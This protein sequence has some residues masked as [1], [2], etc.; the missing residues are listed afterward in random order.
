VSE[1]A[2]P[3]HLPVETVTEL[4]RSASEDPLPRV[5]EVVADTI[6]MAAGYQTMTST[7][8]NGT[9]SRPCS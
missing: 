4:A 6:R 2:G 9:A 7:G 8:P 1:A 5:F 3:A